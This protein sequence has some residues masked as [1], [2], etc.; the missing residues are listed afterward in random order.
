MIFMANL[1]VRLTEVSIVV[2]SPRGRK[3]GG[4]GSP[5]K[6][7]IKTSKLGGA[8]LSKLGRGSN[9]LSAP[10]FPATVPSIIS[11]IPGAVV[12]VD[13]ES[14]LEDPKKLQARNIRTVRFQLQ[15]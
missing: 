13:E 1:V 12:P 5:L 8:P 2:G 11:H 6:L 3:I 14:L 4:V 15:V 7:T 9:P 10:L